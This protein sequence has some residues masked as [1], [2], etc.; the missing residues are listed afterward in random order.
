MI[1]NKIVQLYENWANE[2][3]RNIYKLPASGSYR[4]YYRL[5]SETKTCLGVH[6]NDIRENTAF[7]AFTGTFQKLGLNVPEIYAVNDLDNIYLIEDFGDETLFNRIQKVRNSTKDNSEIISLYKKVLTELPK[8]QVSS[9][10]QIDYKYCYPR[11]QFDK[12][13]MM[14]DLNYFKYYFLKLAQIPFDEQLLEEDFEKFTSFLLQAD[15]DFF[16]YRDFQSRNIM[17]KD[18]VPYFIDY[19]GGR[20]GCLQYDVAS[21]LYDAKADLNE[22]TRTELLDFYLNELSK[23]I[24]VDKDTFKSFFYPF[25]LIRILQAMGAYGFRGFYENKTVF[26]QSIPYA[27]NN[28]NFILENI[29]LKTNTDYLS[30]VLRNL[31]NSKKLNQIINTQNLNIKINSFSFKKQHPADNSGNG[32]GFVFDCR[33]LPNPGR[34]DYFK[35]LNGKDSEVIAY[36]ENDNNVKLFINY[37]FNLISI[38]IDNY[39]ERGFENLMISFGCTGGQHRSVYCA[40]QIGKMILDK[41]RIQPDIYHIEQSKRNNIE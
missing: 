35:Q 2:K 18:E 41:Y 28:L 27:I 13:S 15:S 5:S 31:K 11:K 29:K 39:I 33:A 6:N 17:I 30:E 9:S 24:E 34:L 8:F 14:W 7:I 16:L 19:Q 1:E 23:Y 12:Q 20:K 37:V 22:Q 21:L 4:C 25:V 38:S 10:Q 3:V 32:G 26:L 36:L 40:E